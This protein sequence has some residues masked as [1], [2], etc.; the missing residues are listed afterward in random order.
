MTYYL[1]TITTLLTT[2]AYKN[3]FYDYDNPSVEE[4]IF[5]QNTGGEQMQANV[6]NLN[7]DFSIYIRRN[8]RETARTDAEAIFV[9][10]AGNEAQSAGILKITV[11]SPELFSVDVNSG[12]TSEFIING[13]CL[14]VDNALN[15]IF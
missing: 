11:S 13:T 8:K 14:C 15:R 9:L 2:A 4:R 1:Q 7:K 5:L 10:L 12:L 3:V 6:P